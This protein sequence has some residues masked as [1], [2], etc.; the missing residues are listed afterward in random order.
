MR[1]RATL[2]TN[3]ILEY[4]KLQQKSEI[5]AKLFELAESGVVEL[6]ATARIRED[7]GITETGSVT[8]L[9]SW[10]IGKDRLAALDFI[11][12]STTVSELAATTGERE[13]DWRDWDHLHAHYLQGRDVFLTWDKALLALAE[14]LSSEFGIIVLTPERF[15]EQVE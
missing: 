14:G 9:G 7:I 3:L 13:P 10:R 5:I 15:I 6:A 2:D 1:Q 4:W 12:F 8:R 11:D